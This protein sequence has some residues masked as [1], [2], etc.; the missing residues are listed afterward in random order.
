MKKLSPDY[1]QI[2][3]LSYFE[4]LSNEEIAI[5]MKKNSRQIRN[6]L[7]RAKMSLRSVLEKEGFDYEDFG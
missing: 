2:L 3:W 1:R 7:Y 4:E 6:L 5:V